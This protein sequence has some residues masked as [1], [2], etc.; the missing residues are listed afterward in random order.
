MG[1]AGRRVAR[2]GSLAD[3][4]RLSRPPSAH[5]PAAK[6]AKTARS[7]HAGQGIMKPFRATS[8][9]RELTKP[10]LAD[11]GTASMRFILHIVSRICAAANGLLDS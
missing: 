10:R 3:L 9:W 5:E 11:V 7:G 1:E 4:L 8:A 2:L 6:G